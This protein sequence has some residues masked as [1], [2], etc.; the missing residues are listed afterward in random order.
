[1]LYV[2][3]YWME[4]KQ[5]NLCKQNRSRVENVYGPAERNIVLIYLLRQK[6]V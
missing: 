5:Q 2:D 3:L 1:M 4:L 6:P